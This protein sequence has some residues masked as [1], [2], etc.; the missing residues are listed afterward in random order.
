MIESSSGNVTELFVCDHMKA[1]TLASL[2]GTN[3]V[4]IVANDSDIC[5]HMQWISQGD[6]FTITRVA[7]MQA[8]QIL[9]HFMEILNC[10]FLCFIP[11]P[12]VTQRLIIK[13]R[14]VLRNIL[15]HSCSLKILVKMELPV[16]LH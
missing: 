16:M 13:A 5:T 4:V 14:I 9:Q 8:L 15:H 1:D 3:N 7:H 6:G 10:I 2:Q 11:S 12:S